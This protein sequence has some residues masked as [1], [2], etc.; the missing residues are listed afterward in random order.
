MANQRFNEIPI[1]YSSKL[2]FH[3]CFVLDC[4][5]SRKWSLKEQSEISSSFNSFHI[6]AIITALDLMDTKIENNFFY[7]STYFE[8]LLSLPRKKSL[9]LFVY[10]N[11]ADVCVGDYRKR[12]FRTTISAMVFREFQLF[13]GKVRTNFS[14]P[15][16]GAIM[17]LNYRD[18]FT[19]H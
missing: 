4:C 11:C 12:V 13:Y 18:L 17:Q 14:R 5:E 10:G 7:C 9:R 15:I 8:K 3:T 19:P 16:N 2:S 1:P 6:A